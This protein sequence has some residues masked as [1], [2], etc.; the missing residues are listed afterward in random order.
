KFAAPGAWGFYTYWH[1]MKGS[2]D[3]KFWGNG[4]HPAKPAVAPRDR[5]Q[6]VE[7]MMKCNSTP[8]KSDGE[9]ALWLDGKSI[10]HLYKSAIRTPW[11]GMGF[12]LADEGGEPFE[13]FHWRTTNDLKI[14]F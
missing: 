5:W 7:V 8:E 1:E 6:C 12:S 4:L 9:L 10:A 13:G 2:A 3:G 11:T 14:N